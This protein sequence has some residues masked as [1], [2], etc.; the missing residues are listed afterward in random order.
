MCANLSSKSQ[1]R[2]Y[3]LGSQDFE[4]NK[5]AQIL[6]KK[7]FGM[8]FFHGILYR[9]YIARVNLA[10]VIISISCN[11]HCVIKTKLHI[12]NNAK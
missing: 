9:R 2:K 5:P 1:I 8:Y 7:L 12:K 10:A 3:R 4:K 11:T 6:K